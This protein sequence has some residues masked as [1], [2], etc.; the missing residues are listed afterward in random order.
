MGDD[1]F[2]LPPGRPAGLFR[3]LGGTLG[4][5]GPVGRELSA[6]FLF[7]LRHSL[8]GAEGTPV[9]AAGV[10]TEGQGGPAAAAVEDSRGTLAGVLL[11][12]VALR[13]AA[14]GVKEKGL[15]PLPFVIGR[16]EAERIA[17]ESGGRILRGQPPLFSAG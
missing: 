7:W 9:S 16:E 5:L 12:E 13:L 1:R 2:G 17:G 4:S 14:G 15:L 6:A 3:G 10:W 11:A 8:R